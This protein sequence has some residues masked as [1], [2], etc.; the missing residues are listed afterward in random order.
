MHFWWGLLHHNDVA[1]KMCFFGEEIDLSL[2]RSRHRARLVFPALFAIVPA[3][4]FDT[5]DVCA[6]ARNAYTVD[7]MRTEECVH[8]LRDANL[9]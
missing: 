3:L 4:T 9:V 5:I 2:S 7:E 8:A 6:Y 1:Q